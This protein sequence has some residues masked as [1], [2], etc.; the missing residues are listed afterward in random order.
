VEAAGEVLVFPMSLLELR[1]GVRRPGGS[2]CEMRRSLQV[3]GA[4]FRLAVRP[5]TADR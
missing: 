5:W 1:G 3:A 4:L 2:L